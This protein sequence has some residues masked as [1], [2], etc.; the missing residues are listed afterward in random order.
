MSMLRLLALEALPCGCVAGRYRDLR[1]HRDVTYIED[2]AR[3]CRGPNHRRN[4]VVAP[5]LQAAPRGGLLGM[6]PTLS[7]V[8]RRAAWLRHTRGQVAA[9]GPP[10]VHAFV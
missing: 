6:R 5:R 2:K 8:R 7:P 1:T 4:H 9:G 10:G 3:T